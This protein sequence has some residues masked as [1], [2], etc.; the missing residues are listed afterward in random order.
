M[1]ESKV[2][3][4]VCHVQQVFADFMWSLIA[5]DKPPRTELMPV[6][7]KTL[8]D[9]SRNSI[10]EAALRG[11]F[12]HVFFMDS[13]QTFP[14]FALTRLLSRDKDIIT[15]IYPHRSLHAEPT[16]Y[17]SIDGGYKKMIEWDPNGGPFEI[18]ACGA[19]CLLIRTEVLRKI[20]RP[21]FKVVNNLENNEYLGED[22]WF[23][24]RAKEEGFHIFADPEVT[25][26][27]I[28]V[29]EFTIEMFMAERDR[30]K[31]FSTM[32]KKFPVKCEKCG[33]DF[34][35]TMEGEMLHTYLFDKKNCPK[36]TTV[37]PKCNHEQEFKE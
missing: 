34:E 2:L 18:A 15:G 13:D 26:G 28:D 20:G 30:V 32:V 7:T 33:H 12:T 35:D 27:H 25:C 24:R 36:L 37:C 14:P 9:S 31:N 1:V 17:S 4:G 29:I 22:M 16:I 23:C 6:G 10:T 21:H 8:I 5:L 19:G 11:G 3:I